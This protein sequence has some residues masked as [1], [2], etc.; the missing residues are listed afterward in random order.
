MESADLL[1]LHDDLSRECSRLQRLVDGL[2]ELVHRLDHSAESVEAAALR[3]HSFYTD[4][5]RMLLLV[6]RVVNGGTPSQGEGWHRRLL[7]R[8]AMNTDTRPAVLNEATQMELQEFLRF[9]QLV[10]NLYADEL[11][12]EPMERLIEKLQD[13]W[14]KLVAD[15]KDFQRW[16]TSIA[17]NL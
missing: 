3:L 13:T 6:S 12:V 15:I 7:E 2:N 8:M 17:K 5:E 9:R 16:L 10:R 14:P 11:R 1:E 4:V